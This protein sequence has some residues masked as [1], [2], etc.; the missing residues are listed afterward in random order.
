MPAPHADLSVVAA[1]RD[2]RAAP[3]TVLITG[4]D[5]YLGM[6]IARRVLDMTDDTVLL[7]V[8]AR[9]AAALA[10]RRRRIER[11]LA[12]YPGRVVVAGGDLRAAEPFAGLDPR[13]VRSIVHA[14]ANTR[15]TVTLPAAQAVNIDGTAKL[16]AFASR[17]PGLERLAVL[18]TVYAS[19]LRC[20]RIGEAPCAGE[21][22]FANFYEWSKWEAERQVLALGDALPWQILRVATV[23]ADDDSG[24]IAQYNA[25]HHTLRL[26]S[27]GLLSLLPGD[28]A[29]P[30]YF[31]TGS[32]V[33]D[34]VVGLGAGA[35]PGAIVHIA[36]ERQATCTLDQA[37]RI[38]WSTFERDP[39]FRA[40]RVL[41]PL[42][43]DWESF[44][45]LAEA[46]DGLAAEPVRQ[47]LR[48][49]LPFA[50]QLFIVKDVDNANLRAGFAGY[51]APDALA[52]FARVCERLA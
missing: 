52:L 47:A 15:F 1:R 50:R 31:V 4:G 16:L 17:C 26:L 19:G 25:V 11:W 20:A 44:A 48:A 36:P 5:G 18:S 40:R 34:A 3:R 39:S 43:C 51:R 45:A 13:T 21:A 27:R 32:M 28:P 30:L 9:D 33:A 14:A 46:A 37:V 42:Y 6:R 24:A 29:T 10:V 38:A 7:W 49:V 2:R 12:A 22:G 41:P 35:A 8:R 23:I